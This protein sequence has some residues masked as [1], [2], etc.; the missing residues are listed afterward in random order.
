MKSK[1]KSKKF[2]LF[3]ALLA[4]ISCTLIGINLFSGVSKEER[5]LALETATPTDA[6]VDSSIIT[7]KTKDSDDKNYTGV[8]YKVYRDKECR[9]EVVN[10]VLSWNGKSYVDSDGK[11]LVFKDPEELNAAGSN[12]YL[13]CEKLEVGS[14]FYRAEENLWK[15]SDDVSSIGFK[16]TEKAEDFNVKSGWDSA[17]NPMKVEVGLEEL[18]TEATTNE[19]IGIVA[20]PDD[21]SSETDASSEETTEVT[22]SRDT[23]EVTTE[24]TS[25]VTSSTSEETSEVTTEEALV[26]TPSDV[27]HTRFVSV[28]RA[29]R[30]FATRLTPTLHP[31]AVYDTSKTYYMFRTGENDWNSYYVNN[32]KEWSTALSQIYCGDPDANAPIFYENG[33]YASKL[34]KYDN[35]LVR[36]II[37]YGTTKGYTAEN[38]KAAVQTARHSH[39]NHSDGGLLNYATGQ[40]DILTT[41]KALIYL[42]SDEPDITSGT[43]KSSAKLKLVTNDQAT[44]PVTI[45]ANGSNVFRITSA[46]NNNWTVQYRTSSSETWKDLTVKDSSHAGTQLK[47]GYQVKF[48]RVPGGSG[49]ASFTFTADKKG[50][51]CYQVTPKEGDKIQNCF[52]LGSPVEY[53]ATVK[54]SFTTDDTYAYFSL[55]KSATTNGSGRKADVTGVRYR[56]FDSLEDAQDESGAFTVFKLSYNGLALD[57]VNIS[58]YG[59]AGGTASSANGV[60]VV[61]DKASCKAYGNKYY[62]RIAVNDAQSGYNAASKSYG[63]GSGYSKVKNVYYFREQSSLTPGNCSNTNGGAHAL[64]ADGAKNLGNAG[65]KRDT[66]IYAVYAVK[67]NKGKNVNI[68]FFKK[69]GSS[70]TKVGAYKPTETGYNAFQV[71]VSS[72]GTLTKKGSSYSTSR[73]V[74][75]LSDISIDYKLRVNKLVAK[76]DNLVSTNYYP[77][78]SVS[79]G[80]YK[81]SGDGD[82]SKSQGVTTLEVINNAYGEVAATRLYEGWYNATYTNGTIDSAG[83]LHLKQPGWY[84]IEENGSTQ[85]ANGGAKKWVHVSASDDDSEAE[86]ER[87][88]RNTPEFISI[89]VDKTFYGL[90]VAN[91]KNY[92]AGDTFELYYVAKESN[93]TAAQAIANGHA[94]DI[95][96][97]TVNE[98]GTAKAATPT[99]SNAQN[100]SGSANGNAV[101]KVGNQY[102]L[103]YGAKTVYG[104]EEDNPSYRITKSTAI[105]NNPYATATEIKISGDK[106]TGLPYGTY[107]VVQTKAG[108]HF[109]WANTGW[110]C[111]GRPAIYAN[112]LKEGACTTQGSTVVASNGTLTF[113]FVGTND[114]G[115][116]GDKADECQLKVIKNIA[117]KYKGFVNDYTIIGTEFTLY[118]NNDYDAKT[119]KPIAVFKVVDNNGNTKVES[120]N[121]CDWSDF[122]KFTPTGKGTDT[123]GG[124]PIGAYRLVETKVMPSWTAVKDKVINFNT[125][126]SADDSVTYNAEQKSANVVY[127]ATATCQETMA[128]DPLRLEIN[129]KNGSTLS[130]ENDLSGAQFTVKVYTQ[131]KNATTENGKYYTEV[132]LAG[133][134]PDA[135]F[136]VESDSSGKV[137]LD[138]DATTGITKSAHVVSHSGNYTKYWDTDMQIYKFPAYTTVSIEETKAPANY[139]TSG[140]F[141]YGD[142]SIKG[143]K[144]IGWFKPANDGTHSRFY[145]GNKSNGNTISDSFEASAEAITLYETPKRYNLRFTKRDLESGEAMANVAFKITSDKG[146]EH[147]VVTD[148]NGVFD[149]AAR[150]GD[151]WSTKASNYDANKTS[152]TAENLWFYGAANDKISEDASVDSTLG[153]VPAGTYTIEEIRCDANE[154]YQLEPAFT[155]NVSSKSENGA[156]IAYNKNN[157]TVYNALNPKIVSDATEFLNAGKDQ[158]I[159]DKV[160]CSYLTYKK[161]YTVTGVIVGDDAKAIKNSDGKWITATKTFTTGAAPANYKSIHEAVQN[162][163]M[164]YTVDASDLGGKK[165]HVFVY[166]LDG[167]GNLSIANDGTITVS[168]LAEDADVNNADQTTSYRMM[169]TDAINVKSGNQLI[170][171]TDN[172]DVKDTVNMQGLE[173]NTAF[174]LKGRIVT[175]D[176]E[177]LGTGE[178]PFTSGDKGVETQSVLFTGLKL[179]A[180]A[181]KDI[182]VYEELWCGDQKIMEH[183]DLNDARQ[184]VHVMQLTT[185]AICITSGNH[186]AVADENGNVA[187]KDTL[188]YSNALP[189]DYTVKGKLLKASDSSVIDNWSINTKLDKVDGTVGVDRT[190]PLT[191]DLLGCDLV[192]V[193]ELYSGDT[194]VAEHTDLTDV[195]QTIKIPVIHTSLVDAET[196]M[197]NVCIGDTVNLVDT[198]DYGNVNLGDKFDVE[199]FLMNYETKEFITVDGEKVTGTNSFTAD[200]TGKTEVKF[201]FDLAKSGLCKESGEYAPIVCYEYLKFEDKIVAKHEDIEDANQTVYVPTIGTTATDKKTGS[202][203]LPADEDVTIQDKVV[204]N[205]L[206]PGEKYT[207]KGILMDRET[208]KP[209]LIDGKEQISSTTFTAKTANDVVYV[210]FK[211][212]TKYLRSKEITVFEDV[213]WKDKLVATH[214]DLSDDWQTVRVSDITTSLTDDDTKSHNTVIDDDVNLTDLVHLTGLTVG[215]KYELDGFLKNQTKKTQLKVDGKEVKNSQEFTATAE[216]M[217]IKVPYNFNGNKAGLANKDGSYDTIVCFEYL[218]HDGKVIAKHENWK[219]VDQTVTPVTGHTTATDSK[220]GAHVGLATKK[221][222]ILDKVVN[223]G[224]IPGET[225]VAKGYL[226]VKGTKKPFLVDG[227]KVTAEKTFVAKSA[228][229]TVTL[230]Y[231]FNA[232]ALAGDEVVVFENLYHNDIE[233]W[234]HCDLEDD[235]QTVSYPS[236]NTYADCNGEKELPK[237]S[238]VDV[239]DTLSYSKLPKGKYTVVTSA[240]DK[241]T[242]ELVTFEGGKTEVVD[243]FT[244]KD[245]K[246][247]SGTFEAKVKIDTTGYEDHSIVFVERVYEGDTIDKDHL[248]AEHY[249]LSSKDQTVFVRA[250]VKTGDSRPIIWLIAAA[251]LLT[252]GI[253]FTIRIKKRA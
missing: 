188:S 210:Y 201:S 52:F 148:A 118:R 133:V 191:D 204:V 231:E 102:F 120:V 70:W 18:P 113:Q 217:D 38:I 24:N 1:I 72:S 26:A 12:A 89:G 59:L 40:A 55:V 47:N 181:G 19:A 11:P 9:D 93:E 215:E 227:K 152:Y 214:A 58:D 167:T 153:S 252:L 177:V 135:T 22:T 211:V 23:T 250:D 157:G 184:T 25:E 156:T 173:P 75:N 236:L 110:T 92:S 37:Y 48:N 50:Y 96:T 80:I 94:T 44:S 91:N 205:N 138:K 60:Q 82:T 30:L 182:V 150:S 183:C 241:D 125:L 168:A 56:V 99:F 77:R 62:A 140:N 79:F 171:A 216:E 160:T 246:F 144:L 209:F 42:G 147:V 163:E 61:Y 245:K 119:S 68:Y 43:V 35:A 249:D 28:F 78:N 247:T 179:S 100:S 187:L 33:F 194:L 200:E 3:A 104:T 41:D 5:A 244:L 90:D 27:G 17:D 76:G 49:E 111:S 54:I 127:S 129:K 117:E 180:L 161:S 172:E 46:V 69:N 2:A 176:G 225:Y 189:G 34:S 14:Y 230:R 31:Q 7:L 29:V 166:L 8:E 174:T 178:T 71:D 6:D 15:S 122:G 32:K 51:D 112:Y 218:K 53:S 132:E 121:A 20:T 115:V 73:A 228:D 98:Y 10:F 114:A 107:V 154:G 139:V 131:N 105:G 21:A 170:N 199:G 81:V 239:K 207:A 159:K 222:V 185:E 164:S 146:E 84:Y 142:T 186:Y 83:Y 203:S 141:Q 64:R 67:V 134:N 124:L 175:K 238:V 248:I 16:W 130:S 232:T 243:T 197:K 155:I 151:K 86:E 240:V 226:M 208:G 87:T 195:K 251:V 242:K 36:K 74:I 63:L 223:K 95:A 190:I 116:H 198:I 39:S 169:E 162:L 143:V 196:L 224:L 123:L 219:D 253:T 221:R 4:V 66:N 165:T 45:H 126:A 109:G 13:H 237:E 234:S 108:S 202:H 103:N 65:L 57:T 212:N 233:V 192:F 145:I 106:V 158:V 206:I 193:E 85:N 88:L 101:Y 149:S 137:E 235:S 97:F 220:T 213:Y 136:V 229:S 128:T